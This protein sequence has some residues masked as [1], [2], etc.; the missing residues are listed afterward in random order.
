MKARKKRFAAHVAVS[1]G[2]VLSV[3]PAVA[4]ESDDQ[5]AA[6]A[7]LFF[8]AFHEMGYAAMNVGSH[9]LVAG[10]AT[11]Q[12]AA[13]RHRLPLLSSSIVE[14]G[15]GKLVF[16]PAKVVRVG[17]LRIGFVGVLGAQPIGYDKALRDQ[18]LDVRPLDVA[19]REGVAAAKAE[20]AQV[21]VL[22]SQLKRLEVDRAVAAAPEIDVV[23]GTDGFGMSTELELADPALFVDTFSK[24]KFVGELRLSPGD[25]PMRWQAVDRSAAIRAEIS[26]LQSR[27]DSAQNMLAEHQKRPL[28]EASR[29]Y[30]ETDLARLK[31]RVA[32]LQQELDGGGEQAK[33]AGRVAFTAHPI[34]KTIEDD[35][36]IAGWVA[37]YKAKYP[38]EPGH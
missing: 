8:R 19:V 24:G 30:L 12:K 15:S 17:K 25:D 7:D 1:T 38:S 21:I 10:L 23:I 33:G 31:A 36:K 9:D 11:L 4:P 16:S 13:R 32:R 6:R 22:L 5:L 3:N 28:P 34:D 27:I 14:R 2:G 26:G 20:G 35:R 18:K 37:R 29:A